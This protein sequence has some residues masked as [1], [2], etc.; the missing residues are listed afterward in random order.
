[1]DISL[2]QKINK[3]TVAWNDTLNQM[4]FI[5]IYREHYIQ[6]QK[7]IYSLKQYME[8]S[9]V[10]ITSWATKQVSINLRSLKSY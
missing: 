8:H 4:G 3:K 10:L 6:K 9:P 2:R 5:G 1:M 7:N